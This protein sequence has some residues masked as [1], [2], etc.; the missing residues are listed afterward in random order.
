MIALPG[1]KDFFWLRQKRGALLQVEEQ[2]KSPLMI[3]NQEN[4]R[5][6]RLHGSRLNILQS[7]EPAAAALVCGARH[8]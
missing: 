7:A 3:K 6:R 8:P 5:K 2:C 4:Q 1:S